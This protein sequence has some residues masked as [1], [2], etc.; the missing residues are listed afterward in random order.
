[1]NTSPMFQFVTLRSPTHET[2]KPAELDIE[3]ST[4]L[5]R[6][7]VEI[8][9]GDQKQ[10]EKI[11]AINLK[12]EEFIGSGSFLKTRAE[13]RAAVGASDPA[14]GA[15]SAAVFTECADA[16]RRLYETLYDNVVVRTVT[17]SNTNEVFGLL[18]EEIRKLHL[19]LNA[20][21]LEPGD[22]GK[23]RIVLPEGLVLSFSP[24]QAPAAPAEPAAEEARAA[25]A[26]QVRDLTEQ[27]RRL[28]QSIAEYEAQIV[29]ERQQASL[30][31]LD[32]Q[33][34]EA[35]TETEVAAR[36]AAA[37]WEPAAR[38]A[39]AASPAL[40]QLTAT[41]GRL[42]ESAAE[43]DLR[44]RVLNRELILS[45]PRVRYA[46]VG[47]RW[48]AL[49]EPAIPPPPK[50]EDG[51]ILVHAHGCWLKFPFQVADVRLIKQRNVGYVP[52]A[53]V[54]IHN[55]QKG[56]LH[57]RVT[58][59]VRSV[60][61][62]ESLLMENE[63][64]HE[65][66]SRSA[67]TNAFQR[68]ASEVQAEE[69][70]ISVNASVSG[71]YGVVTAS[72]DAGFSHSQSSQSA[73]SSAQ[74]Y[75]REIVERVV[76]RVTSR[77]RKERRER[78]FES[79]TE[80]VEH[81]IDNTQSETQSHVYRV[82]DL[83][84]DAKLE[85]IGKRLVCTLHVAY[86][87]ADWLA[88]AIRTQPGL[89]L[90][91]DPRRT[92]GGTRVFNVEDIT[93]DNYLAFAE[94]YGAKLDQPPDQKILVSYTKAGGS[95]AQSQTDLVTIPDG[96]RSI[97]AYV[98]TNT[99]SGGSPSSWNYLSVLIGRDQHQR[100]VLGNPTVFLGYHQLAGETKTLP[101]S[102]FTP[103]G[104]GYA[105]NVEVECDLEP[106]A[107]LA[108]QIKCYNAIL[109]AYDAQKAEAE[110][111]MTDFDPNL[112]F[113]H[114]LKKRALIRTELKKGVLSRMYR[115]NPF[116]IT[117]NFEVGKV[118]DPDCC[119]DGLNGETISFLERV[120]DWDSLSYELHPYLYADRRNWS[121]LQDL[122]DDDPHFEAFLQ[123][124]YATVRVPVHR[125]AQKETA[126]IN[127]IM[128]N[129]IANYSVV[130]ASMK[131][132]LDEL[133]DEPTKFTTGLN[134]EQLPVPVSVVDLGVFRVPTNLVILECGVEKGVKPIGF[135]Q[136]DVE[137]TD[138]SIPKQYSPAIIANPCGVMA[139]PANPVD[140]PD[141]VDP[142]DPSDPND[143]GNPND[144]G[145]ESTL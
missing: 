67:E 49:H 82:L 41:A 5:A 112:P 29:A 133:E 13:V 71:T 70:S 125:D 20:G 9:E 81:V 129:S 93:R 84:V 134:G 117:D 19:K 21:R 22:A 130:P 131:P 48:L 97:A 141:P 15:R 25:L 65:T 100:W 1:M 123:A 60:E 40:Q 137:G 43:L 88:R 74:S 121:G 80:Q 7:L 57:K 53:I 77:V 12:L 4:A 128:N 119:K 138:V 109:E 139:G 32:V 44:L 26:E 73:N 24:P 14:T 122:T 124:S 68:A 87:Q 114:P 95:G 61:T 144:P 23:L 64:L 27:K 46:L 104:G 56:E 98:E 75:A 50:F 62:E 99:G 45:T 89:S 36:P 118:Y 127:F 72:V 132:L 110:S 90:P 107:L 37:E 8:I 111:R 115:C 102:I 126:A 59:R 55:T 85:N 108:W 78:I 66:D 135:P 96:Y 142:S 30:R 105:L 94:Y 101:I 69:T 140:P 47:A 103:F 63:T 52:E 58:T 3:P 17:K 33:P 51:A 16:S 143:P 92:E 113:L 106:K 120:Y 35:A 116:W 54:H 31:A 136:K 79:F 91:A 11:A 10:P 2:T 145:G 83:V 76:D 18:V 28:Q 42:Q 86:P 39:G 34:A 6:S 38:M